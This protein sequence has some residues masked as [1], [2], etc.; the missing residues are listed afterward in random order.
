MLTCPS[1]FY[2]HHH[3]LPSLP[4]CGPVIDPL[5]C[6]VL[7]PLLRGWSL[8]SREPSRRR[9]LPHAD[10]PRVLCSLAARARGPSHAA[11]HV[12]GRPRQ[13]GQVLVRGSGCN[14]MRPP[15]THAPTH[16][17]FLSAVLWSGPPHCLLRVC[18]LLFVASASADNRARREALNPGSIAAVKSPAAGDGAPV[19]LDLGAFLTGGQSVEHAPPLPS[20][21]NA[22]SPF[23][24]PD[25]PLLRLPTC[26]CLP[27]PLPLRF[28]NTSAFRAFLLCL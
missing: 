15:H 28:A 25:L 2:F 24:T 8:A 20:A 21:V 12:Q 10:G 17:H 26:V 13:G 27:I 23:L 5:C 18:C 9:R 11:P 14:R 19:T 3:P 16:T 22:H 4:T 1:P 6:V 7:V